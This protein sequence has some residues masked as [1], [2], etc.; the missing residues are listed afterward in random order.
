MPKWPPL[1]R[2]C[3][4]CGLVSLGATVGAAASSFA[5]N[6]LEAAS[7]V[8]VLAGAGGVACVGQ[9]H[10]WSVVVLRVATALRALVWWRAR[11]ASRQRGRVCLRVR[12]VRL[13]IVA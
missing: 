13:E 6:A 7:V 2:G 1:V 9:P 4:C 11:A 10:V 3:F 8:R 12:P 5:R